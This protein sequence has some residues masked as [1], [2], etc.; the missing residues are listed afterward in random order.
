MTFNISEGNSTMIIVNNDISVYHA[1][2]FQLCTK[3]DVEKRRILK[4]W[5]HNLK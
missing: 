2:V 3:S 1:C 5:C 4:L